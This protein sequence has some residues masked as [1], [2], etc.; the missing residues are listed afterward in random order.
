MKKKARP[1]FEKKKKKSDIYS[2]KTTCEYFS[3]WPFFN[4]FC[5]TFAS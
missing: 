5:Y 3:D 4:L 1:P 2:D